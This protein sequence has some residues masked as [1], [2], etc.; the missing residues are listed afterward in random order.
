MKK[1]Y[2]Y[3]A[4]YYSLNESAERNNG[5]MYAKDCMNLEF[6]CTVEGEFFDAYNKMQ[7]YG[8]ELFLSG[9]SLVS[10]TR[11]EGYGY[12]SY[13]KFGGDGDWRDRHSAEIIYST[14]E[15]ALATV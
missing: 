3:K 7:E 2:I 5:T 14:A 11:S 12:D 1:Y 6:L 13:I 8:T 9:W 10:R 15:L 4:F